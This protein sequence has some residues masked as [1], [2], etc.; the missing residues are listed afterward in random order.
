LIVS[1][2]SGELTALARWSSSSNR[3]CKDI[4]P[5]SGETVAPFAEEVMMKSMSPERTFC[6]ITGSW[7]SWAPGNWL[8]FI[9]PSLHAAVCSSNRSPAKP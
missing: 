3:K 6:S 7:P 1:L 2:S 8:I 4:T 5:S 9:A